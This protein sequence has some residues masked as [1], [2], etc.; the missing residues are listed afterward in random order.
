MPCPVAGLRSPREAVR[1]LVHF[2]RLVDKARLMAAGRL[3]A[4]YHAALGRGFDRRVCDALRVP[5]AE[6]AAEAVS[7]PDASDEAL[8]AWA[9][10]RGRALTEG[11]IE[12]LSAFLSKRG[13]RDDATVTFE[14]RREEAGAPATLRTYFELIDWDEGR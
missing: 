3:P 10:S 2:P 9:E 6:L 7:R 1:G 13:W 14:R 5:Y 8:L 4:D 11:D 12:V